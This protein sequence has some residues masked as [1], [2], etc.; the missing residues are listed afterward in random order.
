MRDRGR[1]CETEGG[2][3]CVCVREGVYMRGRVCEGGVCTC[4]RRERCACVRERCVRKE[5][6]GHGGGDVVVEV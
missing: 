2:C 6:E 5:G 3:V 4:D 1:V